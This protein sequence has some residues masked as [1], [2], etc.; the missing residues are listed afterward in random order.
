VIGSETGRFVSGHNGGP[1]RPKG[2]RNKLGEKFIAD[3]YADWQKH[4]L[5]TL[6]RMRETDPSGYVRVIAG[7]L[8]DKLEVD[9]KHQIS[10]IERV[11]IDAPA[12]AVDT[13][14]LPQEQPKLIEHRNIK[15]IGD[16][17]R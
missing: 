17:A 10:R 2:S 5:E 14:V 4:G 16:T 8:P 15:D 13:H 9:V 1:G 6:R 12:R 3:A 7:I 11:I